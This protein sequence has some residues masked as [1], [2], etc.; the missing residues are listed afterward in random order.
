MRYGVAVAVGVG[1]AAT[2]AR[3][4]SHVGDVVPAAMAWIWM[5]CWV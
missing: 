5:G 1:V 2:Q 4:V 3:T